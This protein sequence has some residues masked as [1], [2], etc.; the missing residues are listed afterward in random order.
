MK[1]ASLR[2][3]AYTQRTRGG[4]IV[5]THVVMLYTHVVVL[6]LSTQVYSGGERGIK[7]NRDEVRAR[8]VRCVYV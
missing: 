2:Y 4:Y 5:Y 6:I 8:E 1:A 3:A 7:G